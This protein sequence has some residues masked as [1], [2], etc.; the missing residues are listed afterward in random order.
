MQAAE[1]LRHI[2]AHVIQDIE[3]FI[4]LEAFKGKTLDQIKKL[5]EADTNSRKKKKGK[6]KEEEEE[7]KVEDKKRRFLSFMRPPYIWNFFEDGLEAQH[8]IL[9]AE[10]D[11]AKCYADGRV[12]SLMADITQL[13][14]HLTK[15]EEQRWKMLVQYTLDIFKA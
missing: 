11:P 1:K 9:R 2:N 13:G 4:M 8:H 5:V 6:S 10:A 14:F 15:H 3:D 12:E 7:E